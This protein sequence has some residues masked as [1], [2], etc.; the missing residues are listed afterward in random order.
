MNQA[1][2][3]KMVAEVNRLRNEIHLFNNEEISESALDELKHQITIYETNNPDKIDPNSPNYKVAGGILEGFQKYTH[4]QRMLSLNDLFSREELADWEERWLDYLE[5]NSPETFK[6]LLEL[7]EKQQNLKKPKTTFDSF[8]QVTEDSDEYFYVLEPKLDGLALSLHYDAGIL[9][10]AATRGDGY[11]GENV[12]E[13]AKQIRSIPKTINYKGKIEVRGECFMTVADFEQ[14]NS[15]IE[16]GKKV[17]RMGKKG[18]EFKFVNPRNAAAG[19]LRQLDPNI[20]AER[21]LNFVAYDAFF[22]S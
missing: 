15:D 9:V 11:V 20:V 3:Q 1:Q 21:N 17:G 6:E 4:S 10:T 7:K 13:N 8:N 5:K 18:A 19:T 2:Y 16:A 12:T 14:L 22:E